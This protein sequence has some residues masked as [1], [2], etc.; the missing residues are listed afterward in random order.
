MGVSD[1]LYKVLVGGKSCHGGDLQWSLPT[2]NRAGKWRAGNW[3]EVQG[4][5]KVCAHGIHLTTKPE[6]WYKEDC[7]VFVAESRGEAI[8][9]EREKVCVRAARLLEPV[10][11]PVWVFS[12][13]GCG[14]GYGY[15]YGEGYGDGSGDGSGN[16]P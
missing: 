6:S 7:Q 15:G 9:H 1:P 11:F 5:L 8:S 3:H 12:G 10:R 16:V 2:L 14:D 13:Y 4:K